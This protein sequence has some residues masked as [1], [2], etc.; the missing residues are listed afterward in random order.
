MCVYIYKHRFLTMGNPKNQR[1]QLKNYLLG[2]I[3]GTTILW[4]PEID[5]YSWYPVIV[6]IFHRSSISLLA[7]PLDKSGVSPGALVRAQRP[8]RKWGVA[9]MLPELT[10]GKL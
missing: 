2:I 7:H 3:R 10:I 9:S 8:L 5:R 1:F 4:N 6:I